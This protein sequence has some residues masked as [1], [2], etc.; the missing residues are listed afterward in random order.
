MISLFQMNAIGL[1]IIVFQK[2]KDRVMVMHIKNFT[3][4]L[5]QLF[6]RDQFFSSENLKFEILFD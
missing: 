5:H 2:G 3:K 4:P 6:P 1:F